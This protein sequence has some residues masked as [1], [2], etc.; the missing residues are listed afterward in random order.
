MNL[1][2]ETKEMLKA[3]AFAKMK[4]GVRIGNCARGEIIV[5]EDLLAAL[6]A[7]KV[8]A[9]ALDVFSVEPLPADHP[10]RKHPDI[11]LT[12]HLGYVSAESYRSFYQDAVESV[13]AWLEGR[14]IR[15]L[16]PE[17]LR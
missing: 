15:L 9:A 8:A 2:S 3:A 1:P 17:A 5:E 16:N 11:T 6:D 14:P 12:P 13:E 4:P 7:G 10:F